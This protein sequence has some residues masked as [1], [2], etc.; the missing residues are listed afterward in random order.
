MRVAGGPHPT[1]EGVQRRLLACP[2][3]LPIYCPPSAPRA[4]ARDIT[5]SR[6]ELG[7]KEGHSREGWGLP[8]THQVPPE[9]KG[10][11]P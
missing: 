5:K 10:L 6:K 4:D 8:M 11:L 7:A 9:Q 1:E 2:C 3:L